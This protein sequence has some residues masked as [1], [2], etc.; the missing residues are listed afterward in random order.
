MNQYVLSLTTLVVIFLAYIVVRQFIL[1]RRKFNIDNNPKSAKM[2]LI[3]NI[4]HVIVIIGLLIF[5]WIGL[6]QRWNDGIHNY[7]NLILLIVLT[8]AFTI[9]CFKRYNILFGS[10]K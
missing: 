7:F 9:R 2:N 6:I 5:I 8:I 3:A 4:V 1:K 10:S